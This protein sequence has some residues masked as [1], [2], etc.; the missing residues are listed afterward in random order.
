MKKYGL[1]L[2]LSILLLAALPF[3]LNAEPKDLSTFTS[4]TVSL[5]AQD[6]SEGDRTDNGSGGDKSGWT[7]EVI[8]ALIVALVGPGG[9]VGAFFVWQNAQSEQ[10]QIP[11]KISKNPGF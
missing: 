3:S 4:S 5:Q 10:K 11:K 1:S 9:M 6:K 8:V 2:I 7:P